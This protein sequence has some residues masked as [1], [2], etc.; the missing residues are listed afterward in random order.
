MNRLLYHRPSRMGVIVLGLCVW[1]ICR[2]NLE[3]LREQQGSRIVVGIRIE[4][5]RMTTVA[6]DTVD[7]ENIL[8]KTGVIREM[9]ED[10]VAKIVVG[11]ETEIVEVVGTIIIKGIL[12]LG[13]LIE[14]TDGDNVDNGCTGQRKLSRNCRDGVS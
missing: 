10:M 5:I 7:V 9:I 6:E 2:R 14:I 1:M 12:G 4:V 11:M 8:G 13:L 3:H